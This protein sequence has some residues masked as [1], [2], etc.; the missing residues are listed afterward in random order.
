[1]T[2]TLKRTQVLL[3]HAKSICIYKV[4]LCTAAPAIEQLPL[5]ISTSSE[6]QLH[7]MATAATQGPAGIATI[8]ASVAAGA[9]LL[10]AGPLMEPKNMND[11]L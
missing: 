1:M 8:T 2:N 10:H 7:I 5:P 4:L 3:L 11:A 6:T 9:G